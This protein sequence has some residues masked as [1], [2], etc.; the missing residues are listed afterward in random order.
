MQEPK[1]LIVH[2]DDFGMSRGVNRG[3]TE[4]HEHGIVTS[5]S[6]MVR[7]SAAREAAEYARSHA[8]LDLGLHVDLG[9]LTVHR[10]AEV[11]LYEVVSVDD[12][13]AVQAEILR[14]LSTFRDLM[15]RDPTHI[16]SHQHVHRKRLIKPIF[17]TLAR[18]LGVPL[19]E[20]ARWHIH[21]TEEFYG[22]GELGAPRPEGVSVERLLR[23]LRSLQPGCTELG[24]HPGYDDG[25]STMYRREREIELKTLTDRRVRTVLAHLGV[26]LTSFRDVIARGETSA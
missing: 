1:Y 7:W 24:C 21:Y 13:A 2:A 14:Q 8:T 9:E 19:R 20:Q 11:T 15:G 18:R 17:L 16:D 26:Q 25:L 6:L 10:G 3:I 23:I 5:A 22:Q 12:E 4:A